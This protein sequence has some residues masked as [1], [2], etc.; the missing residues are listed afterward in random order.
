MQIEKT[1]KEILIR[2]SPDIDL[3]GLQR[4]L[5]L[6]KFREI[7]AKSKASTK[8]IESLATQSKKAWWLKNKSHYLK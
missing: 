8:D 6:L 5:D 3:T 1:D 7:T 2:L 4:V